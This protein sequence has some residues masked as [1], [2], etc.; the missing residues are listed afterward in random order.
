MPR[1]PSAYACPVE[2]PRSY[3]SRWSVRLASALVAGLVLTLALTADGP[4]A[5]AVQLLSGL[6]ALPLLWPLLDGLLGPALTV[7]EAGLTARTSVR[8]RCFTWS[9]VAGV[10][11]EEGRGRL[12]GYVSI[13][14][15]HLV[16]LPAWRLGTPARELAAALA[17]L[18]GE[19]GGPDHGQGQDED[20][21][22]ASGHDL[23]DVP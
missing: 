16:L 13:D 10:G 7:Q 23:R 12:G 6:L 19:R 22:S 11:W 14:A 2:L 3:G 1:E 5:P 9:T 17:Q 15:E 20:S 18:A 21:Q 4:E 8:S